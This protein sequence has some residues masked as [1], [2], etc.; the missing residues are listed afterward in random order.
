[1]DREIMNK[2]LVK[3]A[4]PVNEHKKSDV[5]DVPRVW[6]A[7]WRAHR[8]VLTGRFHLKEY[9]SLSKG[10]K[11]HQ[12]TEVF[13]S[14]IVKQ[15]RAGQQLS[16]MELIDFLC[17]EFP[18]VEFGAIQKLVNM[19]LKYLIIL[20]SITGECGY[21]IDESNCHCPIDSIILSKLSQRYTPWTSLE[22]EEYLRIQAEVQSLLPAE[23][24]AL[25][26][27]GFDFQQW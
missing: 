9:V 4:I 3:A 13:Y 6:D 25:G 2:F 18:A 5:P 20:K 27:V 23:C 24:A 12:V 21:E 22:K 17:D 10:E 7:V 11:K 8:D 19:T 1:M 16:S 15:G 14:H 26:N